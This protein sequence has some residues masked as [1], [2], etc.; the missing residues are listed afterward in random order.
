MDKK[1]RKNHYRSHNK[2]GKQQQ[3][4]PN[5]KQRR[6]K[7]IEKYWIE[8][9][10]EM[11]ADGGDLTIWI[12]RALLQ[13]GHHVKDI[14]KAVASKQQRKK[15]PPKSSADPKDG[16]KTDPSVETKKPETA[17]AVEAAK[18]KEDTN[19]PTSEPPIATKDPLTATLEE[20][21]FDIPV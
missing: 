19:T 15:E 2:R 13:D 11:F 1:R 3:Q 4:H 9:I 8:D 17:G 16:S 14:Q 5:K 6:R 7:P 10:P 20:V 12:T 21:S 18:Q